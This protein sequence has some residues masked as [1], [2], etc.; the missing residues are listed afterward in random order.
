MAFLQ[1]G[2]I[3]RHAHIFPH[4]LSELFVEV[5][6]RMGSFDGQQF[7]KARLDGFFGSANSALS[8]DMRATR[9]SPAR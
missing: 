5:I 1:A 3:A 8:V 4:D 7:L 6:D 9:I 2:F